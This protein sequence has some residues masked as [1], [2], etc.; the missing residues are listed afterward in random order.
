VVQPKPSLTDILSDQR[1][2]NELKKAWNDSNPGAPEVPFGSPG[3][4]KK[5]QGGWIVWN[6][7]TGQLAVTR[8]PAGDRDGLSPI[9]GTR[10]VDTA[11]QEVVAWFHTH[12]NTL[13]EGYS[14]DPSPRDIAFQHSEAKVPGIIETH[15]GRKTIPYP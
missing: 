1:V 12:P 9:V 14:Q 11:D 2:E 5:E 15:E 4:L 7:K 6:R 10:P 13:A 3:S 8:V